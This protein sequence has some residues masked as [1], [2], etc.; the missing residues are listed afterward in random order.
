LFGI[1]VRQEKLTTTGRNEEIMKELI[2]EKIVEIKEN[3]MDCDGGSGE[4][5]G[6]VYKLICESGK[7]LYVFGQS[8]NASF[9]S[10]VVVEEDLEDLLDEE[11]ILFDEEFSPLTESES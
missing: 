5:G 1:L 7:V 4:R 2:G 8:S 9:W 3:E 11:G 10:E 6:M